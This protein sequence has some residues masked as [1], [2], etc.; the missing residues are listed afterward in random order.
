M[1]SIR[2]RFPTIAEAFHRRLIPSI[3]EYL[4]EASITMMQW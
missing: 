3:L 1:V 4:D 2:R